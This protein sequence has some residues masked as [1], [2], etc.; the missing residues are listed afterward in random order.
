MERLNWD[1]RLS[2]VSQHKVSCMLCECMCSVFPRQEHVSGLHTA[3]DPQVKKE[4]HFLTDERLGMNWCAELAARV[5]LTMKVAHFRSKSIQPLLP[6]LFNGCSALEV[7]RRLRGL[8]LEAIPVT[9]WGLLCSPGI[10]WRN[11]EAADGRTL[12]MWV[13]AVSLH[14]MTGKQS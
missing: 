1:W 5:K 11:G 8:S 7:A 4:S 13:S 14:R 12:C 9:R 6:R 2:Q 10:R 3:V